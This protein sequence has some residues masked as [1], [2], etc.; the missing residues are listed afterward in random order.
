[1]SGAE[2]PDRRSSEV[3]ITFGDAQKVRELDLTDAEAG[4]ASRCS[5]RPAAEMTRLS[6]N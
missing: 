3:R 4:R 6:Q 2:I 1:M 5:S